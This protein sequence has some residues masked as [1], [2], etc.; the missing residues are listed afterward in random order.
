MFLGAFEDDEVTHIEGDVDPVRDLD[1][2]FNELR[3]KDLEQLNKRLAAIE[4]T[5]GRDGDKHK[6]AEYVSHSSSLPVINL[7]LCV[8]IK[9][10]ENII[11]IHR[12]RPGHLLIYL[13]L[14]HHFS[15]SY[16]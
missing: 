12:Q 11:T 14:K 8:K 10:L 4:K 1:I 13:N 16:N 7:S 2:I 15:H 3:A 5:A 9:I 6:K